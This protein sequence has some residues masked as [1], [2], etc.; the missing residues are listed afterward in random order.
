[1]YEIYYYRNDDTI[2]RKEKNVSK[3][4]KKKKRRGDRI[5]MGI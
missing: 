4:L 3:G 1:L 2:V 5:Y